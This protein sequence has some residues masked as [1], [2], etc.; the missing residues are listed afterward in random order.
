MV[1]AEAHFSASYT[2][3]WVIWNHG[4]WQQWIENQIADAATSPY[5]HECD[6]YDLLGGDLCDPTQ[7]FGG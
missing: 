5:D 7:V 4:D 6:L 2:W 3:V 1:G